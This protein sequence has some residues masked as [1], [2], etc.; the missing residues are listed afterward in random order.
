[1]YVDTI[2]AGAYNTYDI[3][4]KIAFLGRTATADPNG[5]TLSAKTAGGRRFKTGEY[6]LPPMLSMEYTRFHQQ[7]YTE[8]DAGAANLM[9]E[10]IDSNFLA[11]GLGGKM[12]R[13]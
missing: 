12:N 1:M 8:S 5:Y 9:I 13:L 7:G 10:D 4:R 11:S 6:G 3:N 2:F